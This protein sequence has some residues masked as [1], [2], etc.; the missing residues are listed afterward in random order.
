M[1]VSGISGNNRQERPGDGPHTGT[2]IDVNTNLSPRHTLET[3][4]AARLM[5]TADLAMGEVF[6]IIMERAPRV[7][8]IPRL[9]RRPSAGRHGFHAPCWMML[10]ARLQ[11]TPT[12]RRVD[13]TAQDTAG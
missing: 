13:K 11:P 9:T 2:E 1:G 5:R 8:A 10:T 6:S 7:D 4:V 3:S 12:I